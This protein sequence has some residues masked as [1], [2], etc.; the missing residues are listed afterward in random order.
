M[1]FYKVPSNYTAHNCTTPPPYQDFNA[2]MHA[3]FPGWV[4][5]FGVERNSKMGI[6]SLPWVLCHRIFTM[7]LWGHLWE[8]ENGFPASSQLLYAWVGFP[9]VGFSFISLKDFCPISNH[10]ARGML[11][12]C[13]CTQ[14][15]RADRILWCRWRVGEANGSCSFQPLFSYL[16]CDSSATFKSGKAFVKCKSPLGRRVLNYE[17]GLVYW[18]GVGFFLGQ[19]CWVGSHQH[20]GGSYPYVLKVSQARTWTQLQRVW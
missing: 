4:L 3:L 10:L 16:F 12:L 6:L 8:L 11:H 19:P 18:E 14:N 7:A 9:L 5:L 2:E 17:K 20:R 13:A 15:P 1:G